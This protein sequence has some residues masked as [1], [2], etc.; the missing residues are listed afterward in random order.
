MRRKARPALPIPA[1]ADPLVFRAKPGA[2]QRQSPQIAPYHLRLDW[3]MW[4]LPFS[5]TV[6]PQG[7]RKP[8]YELWFL[9]FIRKLLEGDS[10]TLQLLR[11]I[12]FKEMPPRFIRAKYYLYQFTNTEERKSTGAW[13]RRTY[14]DTYLPPVSLVELKDV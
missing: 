6:T 4:F 11:V 9:R 7:I 3:L 12:P 10:K 8:G 14:I 5:V 2:I 13:W 1:G